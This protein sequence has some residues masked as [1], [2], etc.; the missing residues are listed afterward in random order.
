L[1]HAPVLVVLLVCTDH[2]APDDGL[3]TI[4]H[5]RERSAIDTL[6]D[7]YAAGEIGEEEYHQRLAVLRGVKPPVTVTTRAP[8]TVSSPP[9]AETTAPPVVVTMPDDPR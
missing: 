3:A 5:G 7:R 6:R 8:S 1:G 2:R 4:T 9:P